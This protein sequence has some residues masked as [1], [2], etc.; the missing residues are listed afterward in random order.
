MP[1]SVGEWDMGWVGGRKA[2]VD[3]LCNPLG[4]GSEQ[5]EITASFLL[6][7]WI[8]H[9][10][11]GGLN[12]SSSRRGV[13]LPYCPGK[14]D[15]WFSR[16]ACCSWCLEKRTSGRRRQVGEALWD[17]QELGVGGQGMLS[18]L[19][20]W[21]AGDETGELGLVEQRENRSAGRL[22]CF[23]WHEWLVG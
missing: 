10:G 16:G 14:N 22:S 8:W 4:I 18:W 19:F 3:V 15:A 7:G 12:L 5:R 17:F 13:D 2:G 20:C 6:Q 23:S 9:W 1:A 11:G 21:R